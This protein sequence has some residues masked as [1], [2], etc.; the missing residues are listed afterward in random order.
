M[1][2]LYELS[3][4]YAAFVEAYEQ[5][6]TDDERAYVLDALT[7]MEGAI[8]DKAEAY[9]RIIISKEREADTLKAEADR[10]TAKRR[11]AENMAA[12]LKAAMLDAMT[13]VDAQEIQTTIGKWRR[14][15][16]PYTCEIV[17][18]DEVPERYLIP[19]PPKVDKKAIIDEF[20]RTGE[21]IDGVDVRRNNGVIFK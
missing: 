4:N 3:E 13:L 1:A 2:T 17:N 10:L 9:A 21:I 20:K 11:A 15:L 14:R 19:Q 7:Q 5:A 8:T 6:E 12:R 18:A 16:N